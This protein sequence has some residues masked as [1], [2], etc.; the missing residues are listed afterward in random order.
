ML[1]MVWQPNVHPHGLQVG[2][3]P[4]PPPVA[5]LSDL[6][7]S[8]VC[9]QLVA[10]AGRGGKIKK[11]R[12]WIQ[13]L[14]TAVREQM[15]DQVYRCKPKDFQPSG[16]LDVETPGV[17]SLSWLLRNIG[18]CWQLLYSPDMRIITVPDIA[19]ICQNRKDVQGGGVEQVGRVLNRLGILR[20][21]NLDLLGGHDLL[22]DHLE[23]RLEDQD[24]VNSDPR[25]FT[26]AQVFRNIFECVVEQGESLVKSVKLEVYTGRSVY[27]TK[28]SREIFNMVALMPRLVVL[29]LGQAADDSILWQVSQ[30]CNLLQKLQI[31]GNSV[32]DRGVFWLCGVPHS[33]SPPLVEAT[34][35]TPLPLSLHGKCP[36]YFSSP[37]PGPTPLCSTLTHLNMAGALLVTENGL[38]KAWTNFRKLVQFQMQESHLWQVLQD[39]K[40]QDLNQET[41]EKYLLPLRKLELTC[42]SRHDYLSPASLV[43]PSLQEL[44]L[45]NFDPEVASCFFEFS[46][47]SRFHQLRHIKFNNVAWLDIRQLL[48]H[49]GTNLD[50]LDIDNFSVDSVPETWVDLSELGGHCP[51]LRT[52]SLQIAH[53][54]FNTNQT[55]STKLFPL[56]EDLSLKG[57]IFANSDVLVELLLQ[58]CLLS[59]FT[60][61]QKLEKPQVLREPGHEPLND[62]KLGQIVRQ[63]V[64]RHLT[65]FHMTSV[66]QEYGPVLL[67]ETSLFLLAASCSKLERVGNLSKWLIQDVDGTMERLNNIFS[68]TRV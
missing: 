65:M 52:L 62:A 22:E 41:I 49:I 6:A 48:D 53:C 35:T 10:A 30:T 36:Q 59:K 28:E 40:D 15:L 29:E 27:S 63:G 56:L 17:V 11:T 8:V 14:P 2:P 7:S 47:W 21:I 55:K 66:E 43:F 60:F 19:K 42:S 1:E 18:R 57:I 12:D 13:Q 67:G 51:N 37:R 58:T 39:L 61:I 50:L 45:W 4:P 33:T 64:L 24:L 9:K 46:S 26:Y 23:P 44:T 34:S 31:S 20:D 25:V 54:C 5:H 38:R 68:W 3:A 32:T 16:Y